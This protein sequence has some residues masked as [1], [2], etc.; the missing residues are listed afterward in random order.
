M[1]SR[2][3]T[4]AVLLWAAMLYG[5]AF[6]AIAKLAPT[7]SPSAAVGLA[8]FARWDAR[9]Y[10]SIATRG[11]VGDPIGAYSDTAFFPLYPI[12]IAAV[13]QTTGLPPLVAGEAVSLLCLLAAVAS[14]A[15]LAREEGFDGDATLRAILC[16]PT[17]FFFLACYTESLFLLTSLGAL[18]AFRRRRFFVSSIWGFLAALTRPTCFLLVLPML[19]GARERETRSGALLAAAGPPAGLGVFAVYLWVR[20]GTPL[21]YVNAHRLGWRNHLTW[22]WRPFIEGWRWQPTCRASVLAA[23][24]FGAIGIWMLRRWTGYALYVLA[25]LA[26]ILARGNLNGTIRYGVVL[27][28]VFFLLGEG[29]R[30]S[31]LFG[32]LATTAG[33]LALAVYT[34]W[35]ALGF[36]VA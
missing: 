12:L 19:W 7:G 29:M 31:R 35:F 18:L 15:A 24:L 26:L 5:V 17:S 11:Y 14:L 28:P 22:P 16:F 3:W 1:S 20:F 13:H 8:P 33:L 32:W 4:I 9:W 34:T 36:W 6:A 23:I 21:A 2:S 10:A 25:S 27:F 30:R